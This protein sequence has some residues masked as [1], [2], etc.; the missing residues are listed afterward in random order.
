MKAGF[1]RY[2]ITPKVGCELFGFGPYCNRKSAAVRDILEARTAVFEDNGSKIAFIT[3]DLA[4][5]T[6]ETAAETRKLIRERHPEFADHEILIHASHTHSGP[7]CCDFD[8]GW[9]SPEIA[10]LMVLPYR[11]REAFTAALQNIEEVTISQAQ[12][13]CRH[14]GLNRVYD[15]DGP[16]LEEVLKDDWEPAKPELT[17]TVCRVIRI[18]S[19]KTG[20]MTGFMAYFGCH[21]VIGGAS[22][23]Y[24]HGDFSGVAMHNLMREF[25]GS[26]GLFLQGALGDVN[27]GCVYKPEQEALLALDVFAAR[28]ANA[29]R[30][31]LQQAEKLED[32]RIQTVSRRFPFKT[33]MI[34][35]PEKIAQIREE[36]SAVL[37][38]PD[39]DESKNPPRLAAVYLRG[40]K[41]IEKLMNQ[42]NLQLIYELHLVRIG[43]LEFI[44]TPFEVMQAIKNDIHAASSAKYP[45]LMSLC[46]G[47]GGY[48]P[49]NHSIKAAD[50]PG[51]AAYAAIRAPLIFGK[52]PFADIHN[53]L[54]SYVKEL[55]KDLH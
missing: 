18:D 38:K 26:V 55:E 17:D 31:G 28:F 23:H 6:E 39:V 44:G 7:C 11:L 30:N 42:K 54:V 41:M 2:D 9:G 49:D 43:D 45:M 24:I 51:Y 14:I 35:T 5:V 25:P 15:V 10:W 27:T 16:P 12:V 40:L 37:L 36:E 50:E 33:G 32:T 34:F 21:P 46:N 4:L 13:P 3:C 1:G 20:K 22:S 19:V 48:A 29:V 52:L 47:S 8:F 53:E